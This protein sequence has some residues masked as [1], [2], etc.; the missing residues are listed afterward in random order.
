MGAVH[1]IRLYALMLRLAVLGKVQYKVDFLV[2]VI[3]TIVLNVVNVS[4]LGIMVYNFETLAGW[5]IWHLMFLYGLWTMGRGIYSLL[6]WHLYNFEDL[7]VSGGFDAFMIRPLSPLLQLLGRDIGYPGVGDFLVGIVAIALAKN[8]LSLYWTLGYWIFFIACVISA[9]LI[10]LAIVWICGS[11]S[12]WTTRSRDAYRIADRF[13]TLIQQYPIVVFGNWFQVFVTGIL[14]VAFINYYPSVVLL[15]I[16]SDNTL[17]WYYLS[18]LVA[19]VMLIIAGC[20]WTVG[21]KRYVGTG[22]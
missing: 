8:Q 4:F 19:I 10:Q 17:W 15:G 18:P 12:L 9:A 14:P 7:V 2:G 21:V 11:M 16:D 20:I 22:N 6:F 1:N 5:G 13:S 3:S